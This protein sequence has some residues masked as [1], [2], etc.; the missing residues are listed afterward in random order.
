MKKIL[1]LA[2][3]WPLKV[4]QIHMTHPVQEL[5]MSHAIESFNKKKDSRL[6]KKLIKSVF[7]KCQ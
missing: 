6:E 5:K 4:V 2:T 1:T 3:Q 7:A